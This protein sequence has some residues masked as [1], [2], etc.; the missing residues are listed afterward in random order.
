MKYLLVGLT[1]LSMV[2]CVSKNKYQDL[3]GQNQNMADE[4][5]NTQAKVDEL[6]VINAQLQSKLGTT[7]KDKT[8]L[9]SSINEMKVALS[10]MKERRAETDKRIKE[11]TDLIRRFKSLID[12]GK[13]SV[14]II[15]GRMV[16]VLGSDIL[17]SSGSSNLSEQGLQNIQ[18]ITK[19]LASIPNR[20][21]QI[22]GH[23]DNVP[24]KTAKYPSN[25]ELAAARALTVVNTMVANGM[26]KD[27][28]SAATFADSRPV[29]DNKTSEGKQANRRIEIVVVP[30]LSQM[31]GFDEL[32]KISEQQ[33]AK[34]TAKPA[35]Q[36]EAKK[37][38]AKPAPQAEPKK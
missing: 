18:E 8:A 27:R 32:N 11:Y 1:L 21:F 28:I 38:E 15:D 16:V 4:L 10:E 30:D 19:V 33:E 35:P 7:A 5:K 13:L 9:Q 37:P 29:A 22:E 6:T 20:K 36:P 31:P 14:K 12:T 2:G 34:P 3:E 23:T 26:S 25:W 17:F 24:I